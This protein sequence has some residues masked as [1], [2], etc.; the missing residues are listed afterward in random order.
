MKNKVYHFFKTYGFW[1]ILS[2]FLP[3][4][5]M[6]GVYAYIGIY[7]GSE[8]HT[9][10][11]S[12]AFSQ[13]ANF[14]ASF[15]NLLKG[16]GNLFYT[17]FG[18][19]GLNY[20]TFISYYLG[21][22][23][24]PLVF[25]FN[26]V[27]MPE[28]LYYL[29]LIKIGCLGLS[30]WVLSI[31]TFKIAKWQQLSL[32][33]S[34]ALM[35][36]VIAYSEILMWIDALIYLPLI[37][38]GIHRL[39]DKRKPIL[40][41]I[42]YFLLFISN[43]YMGFIVGLFS[44]FYFFG[45][46][47]LDRKR[48]V[49]KIPMYL[50]TS[51]LAGGSSMV[52]ILPTIFDLKNNGEALSPIARIKTE[53]T[54]PLDLIL[55][56]MIGVYDSTK[57]GS[58]PYIFVGLFALIFCVYYFVT[59]KIERKEK[60]FH[61]FLFLLLI[62]SFYFEPLN[63]FWQGMHAPNMFLFR[64]SFLF[65]F[66]VLLVAGYGLEKY[67]TENFDQL[68]TIIFGLLTT[69]VVVKLIADRGDYAY[70]S[71]WSFIFSLIFLSS[72]LVFFYFIQKNKKIVVSLLF[73][74]VC[75]EFVINSI[76][77]TKGIAKEWHYP[78]RKYYADP[79]P[80]IEYLV[81]QTKKE[82]TGFYR[83]ENLDRVSANDSF[84][85]GYSGISMFSS[86]R[87]RHSSYYLNALGYRS[88]GTN[89]NIRYDNNTLLM[90]SLVG[91]KYNLSKQK[92]N[93]FGFH[94]VEK[95]GEFTLYENDYSLPLG[96]LTTDSIYQEGVAESQA[97]LFNHLANTKEDFFS[98]SP[99]NKIKTK[100]VQ[101]HSKKINATVIESYQ[102]KKQGEPLE[103]EWEADIP[104][105]T[106]AY[107]N[108]YTTNFSKFGIAN[109]T[110]EVNGEKRKSSVQE[111]GQFYSLGY[112]DEAKTVRF[113]TIFSDLKKEGAVEIVPPEL[114]LMDINKF[115]TSYQAVK[116]K[117]ID[118]AVSGRKAFG[119][120]QL[121]EEQVLL[122]TIPYDR[123]WKAYIDGKAVEIPTFKEALLTLPI[124][125]GEHTIEFVFLPEGFTFGLILSVLCLLSFSFF[126]YWLTKKTPDINP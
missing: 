112:Y 24:T 36:F 69:F 40:L 62:G 111:T 121:K 6:V 16:E 119:K 114:A 83:L 50:F 58:T 117:G 66:L 125:A 123:G 37:I 120:V 94:E 80:D 3:L 52:I 99:V 32:S 89:L 72:Y 92:V 28:Y 109:V 90:D 41:F 96:V 87:N 74:F 49:S 78:A 61:G 2:F 13:Y 68:T 105:H 118:L 85:Y 30:F 38:L 17:W 44:F 12:D 4:G 124:P 5:I 25:F 75:S 107:F 15:N 79:H 10:L 26:N 108:L 39:M 88:I 47:C 122:T 71:S 55:K 64:Y 100:N 8:N 97:T 35:S 82:N 95:R 14:H 57:F 7:P 51:L 115:K 11:A 84:N 23:F 53:A 101:E 73:L 31:H 1:G 43:F 48:Y 42:S 104:A 29:T 56:N 81:D 113:K 98:F 18:S 22:L 106:Q 86:I 67:E 63:L 54:G 60:W 77:L 9:I 103:I 45:R 110:V 102:P 19:M 59:P 20:W 93:K 21:G 33:I 70:L 116:A 76:E 126:I 46:I 34:Y 65:S 91:M 27:Q